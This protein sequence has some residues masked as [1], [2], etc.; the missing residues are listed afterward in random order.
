MQKNELASLSPWNEQTAF[1][2]VN[3]AKLIYEYPTHLPQCGI[4]MPTI[5]SF[6]P[7]QSFAFTP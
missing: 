4:E 3:E 6:L 5:F 1:V 2:F 7:F